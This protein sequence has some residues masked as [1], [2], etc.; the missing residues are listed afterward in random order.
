MS[1]LRRYAAATLSVL[2]PLG[3]ALDALV[4]ARHGLVGTAN[5]HL[6]E[7]RHAA[8]AALAR[9]FRYK[10]SAFH[11][12]D[13]LY[14]RLLLGIEPTFS[15]VDVLPAVRAAQHIVGGFGLHVFA[16]V[17]AAV[18]D[19]LVGARSA[20]EAVFTGMSLV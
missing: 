15:L 1:G 13:T 5:L 20:L 14:T 16:L 6:S 17:V 18:E 2:T 8:L 11:L 19:H 9:A 12:D 4:K 7:V 3:S 10:R